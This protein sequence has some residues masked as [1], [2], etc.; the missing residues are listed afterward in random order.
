[1]IVYQDI[2]TWLSRQRFLLSTTLMLVILWFSFPRILT[3]WGMHLFF[4]QII[5]L[6]VIFLQQHRGVHNQ[7][8]SAGHFNA[9]EVHFASTTMIIKIINLGL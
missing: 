6:V 3:K 2:F 7:K 8:R 5:C 9:G 1:M 4:S